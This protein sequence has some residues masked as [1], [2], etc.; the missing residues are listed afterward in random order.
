MIFIESPVFTEDVR[1]L[2]DD[3]SYGAL[4]QRL[5]DHPDAGELI[6]DTGGLRKIR[7]ALPGRGKSGGVRVI[8]YHVASRSQIRLILIYRKG[9]KD[10][11]T[12]KEKAAVR[13]LNKD[14]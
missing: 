3:E 9:I 4:Q 11:L 8:Y 1:R 2:L 5:A 12:P 10:D 7:W 6:R 13:E 14:W